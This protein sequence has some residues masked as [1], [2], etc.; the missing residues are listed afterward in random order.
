M[1]A[2]R[3]FCLVVLSVFAATATHAQSRT[4]D[5]PA[6][7]H[8]IERIEQRGGWVVR[9]KDGTIVEAS[10][11]R[12]WATDNDIDFVV[13]LKTLKK[14]DLSFT[15]VTDKGIKKLQALQQLEDL[16]LDT[17]EFL[18]DASMAHLRAN[19]ALRRLV[20]RGVDITDAGMPYVGEMT[21]LRYL[22]ISYTM[23]G[24]VGLEHLPN[25]SELEHL[26][27][28]A[29]LITGLNLNFLKLLPKLKTLSLRGVQRRNAGACWTPNVTDLDLET[30]SLLVGL[31]ELDL[32]V[33]IKLGMG[34]QP[35]APG[36]G[37]CRLTG[38]LQ[39]SDLGVAKLAR[40]KN[41][42]RLNISGARVSAEGVR[43]LQSL[44]LERLSLW[45]AHSLDDATADVLAGM[46]T[47]AHL[48]LSYTQLGDAG[49]RRLARLPNLKYL[50]VTETPITPEAVEAFRNAHPGTF[51]SWA[52]R[53]E[54]RG[55]P[56]TTEKPVIEE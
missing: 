46:P 5:T 24:D 54:P 11:E 37:N 2:T 38:G 8:A 42:K 25:L 45:A 44:P 53:P 49:L 56:L 4:K 32:G 43:A 1:R 15:Y 31:E 14:L 40:L 34:G 17:A 47:L 19:R 16:T 55:A 29:T 39:I 20:V 22:D 18:T 9:D 27:I 3:T 6:V 33:G 36:G 21:G 23:L 12:T 30:I 26:K 35:A 7:T 51:V 28:G 50:Y 41:L 48:D 13:E 52:R 10:L